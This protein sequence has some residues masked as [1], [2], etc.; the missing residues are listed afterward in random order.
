MHAAVAA[1]LAPPLS[2]NWVILQWPFPTPVQSLKGDRFPVGVEVSIWILDPTPEACLHHHHHTTTRLNA[3]SQN[4]IQRPWH[5]H[6][7]YCSTSAA[8][9]CWLLAHTVSSSTSK[10]R[11]TPSND[12]SETLSEK[13]HW[14]WSRPLLM[15]TRAMECRSTCT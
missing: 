12:A 6:D 8:Y 3:V 15:A 10:P 14:S 5:P 11:A 9:C 7:R 2:S 1:R 4:H 13:T